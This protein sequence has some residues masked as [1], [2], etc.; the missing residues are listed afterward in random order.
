M[1]QVSSSVYAT[2]LITDLY[3]DGR[4]DVVVP[5][6]VHYMDVLQVGGWGWGWVGVWGGGAIW[7]GRRGSASVAARRDGLCLDCGRGARA[8]A[9][10]PSI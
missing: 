9:R 5:G 3:S 1:T 6:F 7:E 2:P 10:P 8:P 4:R